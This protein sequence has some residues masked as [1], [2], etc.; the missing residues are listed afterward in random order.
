MALLRKA[1]FGIPGIYIRSHRGPKTAYLLPLK[2]YLTAQ[3]STLLAPKK[4]V[5]MSGYV[6]VTEIPKDGVS[7]RGR[8]SLSYG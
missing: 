8:A 6:G 1:Y 7:S 2:S 3:F 5:F 4:G